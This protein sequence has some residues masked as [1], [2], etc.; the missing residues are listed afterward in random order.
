MILIYPDPAAQTAAACD[1][2]LNIILQH[3]YFTIL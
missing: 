2:L 1:Q 3:P